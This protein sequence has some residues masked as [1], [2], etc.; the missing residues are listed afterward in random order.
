MLKINRSRK[1]S[2]ETAVCAVHNRDFTF[3]YTAEKK[4]QWLKLSFTRKVNVHVPNRVLLALKKINL[5][6]ILG[7]WFWLSYKHNFEHEFTRSVR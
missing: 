6:R 3:S 7:M 5:N 2:Q 4:S 1:H